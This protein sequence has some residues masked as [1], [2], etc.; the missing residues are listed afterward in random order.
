[1]EG[2]GLGL[3]ISQ[4]F[5]RI[6]GGDISV[7]S[8][9]GQGSIFTFDIQVGLATSA[10]EEPISSKRRVIGLEPNQPSYRIL[11]VEDA[12]VNRKLLVEMLEPL[13]FE[14]CEAANG[15]EGVVLWESWSPHLILMDIIMP[16]MDGYEAT[17]QIKRLSC[18]DALLKPKGQDTAIIALTASAFEEQRDAVL[19][20]G[21]DDF[22]PKPFREEVLLE[23]IALHLGV[24]YVYE[25]QQPSN[26]PQL[27]DFVEQLSPEALA[28]MPASW[29]TQLH[30]AA[31]YAD[32]EIMNQ[33]IEQIPLE[34]A[35]LRRALK[36]LVDNF[37]LEQ[38][39]DLTEPAE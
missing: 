24:S 39:I 13:G 6:M 26:L 11:I 22:I 21:C 38:I 33:L 25:E 23:K 8:T 14:V 18:P 30:Q 28:V 9:L 37:Q 2:T 17:W 1:M 4:H 19:R 5:V 3:P 27:P 32:E 20:A 35:F 7:R 10:D 34:H 29:V 36:A 15:Q 31:L 12:A 16:V